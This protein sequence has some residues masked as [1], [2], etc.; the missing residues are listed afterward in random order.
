MADSWRAA[1]EAVRRELNPAR[2]LELCETA[3]RQMQERLLDL[4]TSQGDPIE[5]NAL[6][7]ALRDLWT[8]EQAIRNPRI[9]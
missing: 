5:Q 6:E 2:Q 7:E 8:L 1:Y 3:R 4:A 9:Q